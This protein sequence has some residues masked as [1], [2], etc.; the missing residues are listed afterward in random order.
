MFNK[1]RH[2][3]IPDMTAYKHSFKV[4]VEK[5]CPVHFDKITV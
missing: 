2:Q 1:Y 4:E 5:S 3:H